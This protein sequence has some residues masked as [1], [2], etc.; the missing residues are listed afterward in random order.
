MTSDQHGPYAWGYT[1]ATMAGTMSC[2]LVRGSE[3]HQ[4]RSQFGLRAATR[5]HE[6]GIASNRKSDMLR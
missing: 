3:S 2:E 5:P 4:S 6:A 1:R